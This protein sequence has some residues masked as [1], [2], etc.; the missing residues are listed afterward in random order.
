M[1][2]ERVYRYRGPAEQLADRLARLERH[3]QHVRDELR[4]LEK[5]L[6]EHPDLR[7]QLPTSEIRPRL[8]LV[9]NNA[10]PGGCK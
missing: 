9:V 4:S 6:A 3:R 2:E 10:A 5:F 8:R 7:Q 1:N